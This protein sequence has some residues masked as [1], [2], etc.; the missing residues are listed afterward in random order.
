MDKK[1]EVFISHKHEDKE[2][3][4]LL[5]Q[6]LDLYGAGR[7]SSF[8]SERIAPGADWFEKI[9]E[10]LSTADVLILLFT[11]TYA[12]WD[13]PL[14]EV[15]LATNI[16]DSVPCK[17]ICFHPPDSSPPDPIKFNQA[18]KADIKGIDDFLFRFFCTTDTTG[19]EYPINPK[20]AEDR[21]II[22]GLAEEVAS[23][24]KAVKPWK[25]YFTNFLWVIVDE[26]EVASEEVPDSAWVHPESSALSMFQVAPKPPRRKAWTWA[27][28]LRKANRDSDE[29]WVK[30]LGERFYYASQGENLKSMT[31]TFTCMRTGN[32][33]RPLL[34]KVELRS[35]GSML[36]EIIMIENT[37]A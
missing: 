15:G 32:E 21:S 27:E 30:A 6:R 5:H 26:G 8:I 25:N 20:L 12:T 22:R 33:F 29:E 36:F 10:R 4:K 28:L 31:N 24:F 34:N 7:I 19:L 9:K 1:I 13:W 18:V 17:I 11:S 3:A 37:P 23:G 35:N 14:Y 16:D 2:T